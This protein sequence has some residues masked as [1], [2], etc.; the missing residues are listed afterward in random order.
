MTTTTNHGNIISLLDK[1]ITSKNVTFISDEEMANWVKENFNNPN[2]QLQL[3]IDGYD[4][5]DKYNIFCINP[6]KY[7]S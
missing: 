7:A 4:Y 5:Y 1:N 3:L 6:S 2:T